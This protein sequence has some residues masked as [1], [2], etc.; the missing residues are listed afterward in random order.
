MKDH[1]TDPGGTVSLIAKVL[2]LSYE[3]F[4]NSKSFITGSFMGFQSVSKR[5]PE[6]EN[7]AV[8]S[9]SVALVIT[10]DSFCL[11]LIR[12]DVPTAASPSAIESDVFSVASTSSSTIARTSLSSG[13]NSLSDVG[14][15]RV[16]ALL[17]EV[18]S[19]GVCDSSIDSS[20]LSI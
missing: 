3:N 19:E 10:S 6:G 20:S 18:F 15:I 9:C 1:L 2:L 12:V 4:F 14:K 7:G 5:R 11:F 17:L 8:R 13:V 16:F